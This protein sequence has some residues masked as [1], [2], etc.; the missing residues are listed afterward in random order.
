M[1]RKSCGKSKRLTAVDQRSKRK[2]GYDKDIPTSVCLNLSA[3]VN[4][5]LYDRMA[6]E[7]INNKGQDYDQ[8]HI[9]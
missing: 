1:N 9:H 5:V 7:R 6:K 3:C 2:A 8:L 4:V